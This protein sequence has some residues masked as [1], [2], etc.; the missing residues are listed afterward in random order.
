MDW[1][2]VVSQAK[3]LVQVSFGDAEGARQTQENF[4]RQCPVVGQVRLGVET[5]IGDRD[6]AK[7]TARQQSKLYGGF[8]DSVPVVGHVKG[9]IHYACGDKKGG[10]NAMKAASRTTG[11]IIGGV[12]GIP[13][14]PAGV[15]AGAAA[16]G[17]AMDGITTGVDSA[18]HGKYRPSGYVATVTEVVK[19]PKNPGKWF[20]AV[21][22]PAMDAIAVGKTR[23]NTA[24]PG[25]AGLRIRKSDVIKDG[26]KNTVKNEVKTAVTKEFKKAGKKHHY[27]GDDHDYL[28][29]LREL[30]ENMR[31]FYGRME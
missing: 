25:K 8:A 13:L 2:P 29:E 6:G 16:G 21:A 1:I 27:D 17:Y 23:I 19:D 22:P 12:A 15:A 9:A 20:D 28:D 10:D 7:E 30:N 4:S 31:G 26:V 11:S 14:G 5:A 24:N 3:S 18:I